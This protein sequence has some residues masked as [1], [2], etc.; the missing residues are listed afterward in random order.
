MEGV[1]I[2]RTRT[3]AVSAFRIATAIGLFVAVMT[4]ACRRDEPEKTSSAASSSDAAKSKQ[5]NLLIFP[6]DLCVADST[7][8]E[9]VT[10][11]MTTCAAGEYEAFRLLWSVRE[12]PLRREEFEQGWQAVQRIKV[13]ALEKVMLGPD[14]EANR[15]EGE[16]VYALLA[17]VL[18]DPTQKAGQKEAQRQ[19]VLMLTRENE[20]W[21]LAKAPKPMR[22]W[23][24]EKITS[25]DIPSVPLSDDEKD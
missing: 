6:D 7:V 3:A 11:A 2:V 22:A 23:I 19:V 4:P 17:E 25:G 1:W 18:L 24:K 10:K 20:Q 14:L 9:F 12:D 21:R 15:P 8:N 13:M 16:T 5:P